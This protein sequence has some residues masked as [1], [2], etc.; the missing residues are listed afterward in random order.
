ML[1]Q[2]F[3]MS[4]HID[5]D[6]DSGLT[7]MMMGAAANAGDATETAQVLHDYTRSVFLSAGYTDVE[8]RG[9]RREHDTLTVPSRHEP[10]KGAV[11]DV[12]RAG[13]VVAQTGIGV[14]GGGSQYSDESGASVRHRN[15]PVP[16]QDGALLLPALKHGRVSC[17]VRPAQPADRQAPTVGAQRPSCVLEK[18][19]A[20]NGA[21]NGRKLRKLQQD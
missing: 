21:E 8:K 6:V 12:P 4:A 13:R 10:G 19:K 17:S 18:T 5:V 15:G 14:N 9:E 11:R 20:R 1:V 3:G 16:L 2:T 7:H